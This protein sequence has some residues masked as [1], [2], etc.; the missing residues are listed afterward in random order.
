ML[1]MHGSVAANNSIQQSDCIIS[2]GTRFD[3]RTT[4]NIDKYAPNAMKA[5]KEKRGGIKTC[6]KTWCKGRETPSPSYI[7]PKMKLKI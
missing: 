2:I 3:D 4:G 5:G 1:G 6:N 7:Y